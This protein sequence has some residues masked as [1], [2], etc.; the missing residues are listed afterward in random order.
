M[1]VRVVNLNYVLL[2]HLICEPGISSAEDFDIWG[3]RAEK[4][5]LGKGN[6]MNF[7]SM[8]KNSDISR[9]PRVLNFF[10]VPFVEE[11]KANDGR[12]RGICMNTYEC[13][14][15]EG[16]SY[17]FCALG[18]GV[19]CVFTATCD[20][21]V[22][23]NLTYFVNPDFPDLTKGM[24]SCTLNVKKIEPEISQIRLDFV[25]F[26]LG[27]PNRQTGVC[28]ED[29]FQIIAGNS[30]EEFTL[31]GLNS[32][33]HVYFD[34]NSL[35]EIKIEMTLDK[36]AVSRFWEIIITQMAFTEQA[37]PGCL[38]YF[39]GPDGTI[40]T[41]NFADNGRHLANQDYNICIRQEEGMCSI[42]YEPCH[43][44][45]FRIAPNSL[46][47]GAVP[48]NMD[49]GS[50]DE[51]VETI[52]RALKMCNDKIVLP[53]DS[54][55]LILPGLMNMMPGSCSL[56]HCGLSLCPSGNSPC[57]IESSVTPFNI[58]VHFAESAAEASPEENLGMCLNYE[59]IPC[60]D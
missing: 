24:S 5:G 54:E 60:G 49:E 29:V 55:E 14:I 9:L 19:C 43:E 34:V 21:E 47:S 11:C 1:K 42:A 40:Q 7:S 30:S 41:M 20:Q 10:P 25:H 33:Q 45:A 46:D 56:E 3:D 48:T 39:T 50:G 35:D 58:G 15:Q 59:Q 8:V 13:R 44:N 36:K 12:R 22:I 6:E 28:E 26:N 53:C 31:C 2:M 23:N 32:G 52:S 37:P 17:G 27:Q 57:R 4:N 16:K 38:Q 18:F 51:E